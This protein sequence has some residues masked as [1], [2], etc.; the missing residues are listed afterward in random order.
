MPLKVL[1]AVLLL[2]VMSVAGIAKPVFDGTLYKNKIRDN[3]TFFIP[4]K[5]LYH[6]VSLF[7]TKENIIEVDYLRD[8]AKKLPKSSVPYILDIEIWDVQTSDDIEANANIDKYI[9]VI[10]TMK[11]ARP[12]LKFGYYGVLPNRDYWSPVSNDPKKLAEWGRINQRLKRLAEHVDVVCPSLYAY[13]N[14]PLEW[15]K[16]AIENI[17]RAKEYG[18]PV[19]PFLWSQYHNSNRFIGG[20]FISDK[21]WKE[22]LELVYAHSDGIIIWGGWNLD[23]S[24]YGPMQWDENAPWWQVTKRFMRKGEK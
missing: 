23:K 16:Y 15:K 19:Y 18:K 14:N 2:A 9:L 6:H 17:K 12:D 22:Q 8:V 21:F 10:D 1:I 5:L 24:N 13:Y 4:I 7:R 3:E 20:E 11:Q